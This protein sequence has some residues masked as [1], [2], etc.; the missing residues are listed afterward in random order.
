MGGIRR[1]ALRAT[2]LLAV[3][4]VAAG[5]H[6]AAAS[7][8]SYTTERFECA[9]T[10]GGGQA[11]ARGWF[12]VACDQLNGTSQPGIAIYDPNGA[13]AGRVRLDFADGASNLATDV[14]P[15]PDGSYLYV[16]R[17]QRPWRLDRQADGSYVVDRAWKLAAYPY[18]AWGGTYAATGE[19]IASDAQGAIYFS[20]GTWTSAPPTVLKY[21]PDGTYLTQ[22]GSQ[23]NGS[24]NPGEF[25]WMLAG[26]AATPDGR[27]VY[28]AEVGNNRIQR[29]DV[30][31]DGSYR[32]AAMWGNGPGD[33][34]PATATNEARDGMC[35]VGGKFAAPYDVG[36]DGA[37]S[38]YVINT[39]CL[40]ANQTAE[41]QVF[42]AAG[43]WTATYH[44]LSSFWD[45]V[46]AL[47]IDPR[48][49]VFLPQAGALMRID[50]PV[51]YVPP[52]V[53][54][55]A[56][57]T[58]APTLT[59]VAVPAT[60]TTQNVTVSIVASDDVAV[61]Q[62]RLANEGV[63]ITTAPWIAAAPTVQWLLSSGAGTKTVSVQVRDAAGNLSAVRSATTTFTP[64]LAPD[65]IN[66]VVNSVTLPNPTYTQGITVAIDATDDRGVTG[67]R[68]ATVSGVW[69]A[70]GAFSAQA[71]S[72]LSPN[73]GT[74]GVFVQVRDASGRESNIVYRTTS[75]MAGAAPAPDP[76]PAPNPNP[77]PA[78]VDAAAPKVTAVTLPNPT[79]T[80]T[81]AVTT[82]ASDDIGVTELRLANEDGNWGAWRQFAS[83]TPQLLSP[84][85]GTK[86]VFVQVRDAAGKV[87][88]IVYTKTRLQ[89]GYVAGRLRGNR[90]RLTPAR[91]QRHG[92]MGADRIRG[93][94][95]PDLLLSVQ[96]DR[97]RDVVDCGG[98]K[99]VAIV[100]PEDVTRH[101]E[102]VIVT[103]APFR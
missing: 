26:L 74:K 56:P 9:G 11:D 52:V 46:H 77:N 19:F 50:V 38:V 13:A 85:A 25:W 100:R 93:T 45:K 67:L 7:A 20:A 103:R 88:N 44:P 51:T 48:G 21:A 76:N 22:F 40:Y 18:P 4:L 59:S 90:V 94:A 23:V 58:V 33:D 24:W 6:V 79:N 14:A 41:V 71:P 62:V 102:R 49:D 28:T 69:Q 99:D 65:S 47:G 34:N 97:T 15:S 92:S 10:R 31:L 78:P 96:Y 37:G 82:T 61:S 39:S 70:W 29:F 68:M 57:D 98:G 95:R 53:V 89:N 17:G 73:Y 1:T 32:P 64:P 35:N 86:G 87:S 5:G 54:P 91:D 55:P 16:V 63:D 43:Q 36:I 2:L 84:G 66:P 12:Y 81:I 75:Y 30:Q 80:Q 27:S 8:T 60:T 83:P 72:T 3:T 101:C 42:T